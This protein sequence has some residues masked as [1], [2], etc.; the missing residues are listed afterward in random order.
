M[1]IGNYPCDIAVKAGSDA[2]EEERRCLYVALTRAKK[3]LIIMT[4]YSTWMMT[5]PFLSNAAIIKKGDQYT[6]IHPVS[7]T[8]PFRVARIT[9]ISDTDVSYHIGGKTIYSSIA[10][11]SS[12]YK[13][14]KEMHPGLAIPHFFFSK[15]N[16]DLFNCI[17]YGSNTEEKSSIKAANNTKFRFFQ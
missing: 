12:L 17:S 13:T 9:S 15:I 3:Q 1:N 10:E 11:F 4:E 2:I 5:N 6:A 8:F 7:S 16:I 14:K